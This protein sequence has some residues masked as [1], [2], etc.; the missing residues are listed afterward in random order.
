MGTVTGSL[1]KLVL[2]PSMGEVTFARRGFAPAVTEMARHLESIPQHVVLGFEFGI[3]AR[4]EAD[5]VVRLSMV[6]RE[7]LGFAYEGTAMAFTVR[8]VMGTRPGDRTAR[9]LS[10]AAAPHIFLAYIGVGFAMARLPRPLWK[11]I[12]PGFDGGPVDPTMSWLVIDGYGFDRAYFDTERWVHRQYV[13]RPYPWRGNPDYFPR[14]V[15]QGI[16]RAL[17]FIHGADVDEVAAAVATFGEHRVADLWAGVGLAA[18]YAGAG[19]ADVL[20]ALRAA[21]GDYLPEVALGAVFAATARVHSGWTTPHTE[22]ASRVLCDLSAEEA[23]E[24]GDRTEPGA[25]VPDG[26][27]PRYETWR[28]RIRAAFR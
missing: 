7:F 16:G 21:A 14:A 26:P 9:F 25:A 3:E 15:D 19:D 8:D 28:N 4:D 1:R 5:A 12:L 22:M 13:P 6:E 2:A 20:K 23:V 17:W 27:R 10:G 18:A 11:K 24:L